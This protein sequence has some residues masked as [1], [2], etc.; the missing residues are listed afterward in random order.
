MVK[1]KKLAPQ[2]IE[3][4]VNR[5]V[6]P[7]IEYSLQNTIISES[8][9]ERIMAPL[10]NLIKHKSNLPLSH[11]NSILYSKLF[12]NINAVIHNQLQSHASLI[13][14]CLNSPILRTIMIQQI[15]AAQ[16]DL[17]IPEFPSNN[18]KQLIPNFPHNAHYMVKAIWMLNSYNMHIHTNV[19]IGRAHV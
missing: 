3:Y 17:W 7:R 18:I 8:I 13:M 16:I 6:V 4:L 15:R 19:E 2:H 5:V 1:Y 11:P 10:K 9:A 12:N 14:A